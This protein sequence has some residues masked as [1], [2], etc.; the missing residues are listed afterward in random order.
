MIREKNMKQMNIKKGFIR[1]W[2]V[3]A[4]LFIVLAA[5]GAL[6][7]FWVEEFNL[8]L[9]TVAAIYEVMH[10]PFLIVWALLFC[11]GF[12]IAYAFKNK[13]NS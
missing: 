11:T 7:D 10:I 2:N 13:G 12:W 9:V 4:L 6:G 3:I 8:G 5:I 1:L